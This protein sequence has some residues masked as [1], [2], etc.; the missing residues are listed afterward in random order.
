MA[1]YPLMIFKLTGTKARRRVSKGG[2]APLGKRVVVEKKMSPVSDAVSLEMNGD[3][4]KRK[5]DAD[6]EEQSS[7]RDDSYQKNRKQHSSEVELFGFN[8]GVVGR[9]V[10]D[11]ATTLDTV[12]GQALDEWTSPGPSSRVASL[13]REET[14][15]FE[16]EEN[17]NGS[18]SDTDH[19]DKDSDKAGDNGL[20]PVSIWDDFALDQHEDG[21]NTR[22]H[23]RSN[24]VYENVPH[25]SSNLSGSSETKNGSQWRKRAMILQKELYKLRLKCAEQEFLSKDNVELKQHLVQAK[26]AIDNLGEENFQLRHMLENTGQEFE[27]NATVEQ[28]TTH[29]IEILLAEKAV[30]SQENDRL[31]REN[32]SLKELV[33]LLHVCD[34]DEDYNEEDETRDY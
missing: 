7:R 31:C 34:V 9:F 21:L 8:F 1:N 13:S 28:Q 24:D 19:G 25:T 2:A 10:E 11:I 29:Q 23:L 22:I 20:Q 4:W 26:S 12:I 32:L 27:F 14:D 30:L 18:D 15:A 6:E 3:E 17:S 5:S 16:K 33:E